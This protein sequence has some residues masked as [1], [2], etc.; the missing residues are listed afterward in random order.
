MRFVRS[1]KKLWVQKQAPNIIT[2]TQ[3]RFWG[4][5]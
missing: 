4:D 1:L 3:A 2:N 5:I